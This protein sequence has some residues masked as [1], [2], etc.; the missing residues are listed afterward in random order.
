M[1]YL[2]FLLSV[3]AFL[4]GFA[5]MVSAKSALHEIEAFVLFIVCA[6]FLIGSAIVDVLKGIEKKI[7]SKSELE[8]ISNQSKASSDNSEKS[9]SSPDSEVLEHEF[10]INKPIQRL[11]DDPKR[12][13]IIR[14]QCT[15][16]LKVLTYQKQF[17]GRK[18]K[19]PD[20]GVEFLLP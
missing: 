5:I 20:C 19:C 3:L 16:C 11:G 7:V 9:S 2:L 15:N 12:P 14:A 13:G 17:S 6:V 18:T 1:A 10:K 8:L 4:A